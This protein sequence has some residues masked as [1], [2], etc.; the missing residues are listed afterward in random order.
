MANLMTEYFRRHKE[1]Y[2]L[3]TNEGVCFFNEHKRNALICLTSV[4]PKAIST[5]L[6]CGVE[7]ASITVELI[8]PHPDEGFRIHLHDH[9]APDTDLN[10]YVTSKGIGSLTPVSLKD[11][12]EIEVWF[13]NFFLFHNRLRRSRVWQTWVKTQTTTDELT[14]CYEQMTRCAANWPKIY[15]V[16]YNIYQTLLVGR[17]YL[18]FE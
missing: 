10:E 5:C 3:P 12:R 16:Y 17:K 2:I 18:L 7:D 14:K 6:K 13:W 1:N 15:P 9:I 4:T 11:T 8:K